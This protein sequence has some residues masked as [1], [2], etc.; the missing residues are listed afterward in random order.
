MSREKFIPC[1]QESLGGAHEAGMG[2]SCRN[3]RLLYWAKYNG[4]DE[5]FSRRCECLSIWLQRNPRPEGSSA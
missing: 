2:T 1:E 4:R 3:G 5:R